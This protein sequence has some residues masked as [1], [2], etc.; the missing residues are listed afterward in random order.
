VANRILIILPRQLG[1]VLLGTPLAEVLRKRFPDAKIDWCAHPMAIT[2]LQEN[3]YLNQSFYYPIWSKQDVSHHSL[4]VK[5]KLWFL[6]VWRYFLFL[7]HLRQQKYHIVIDAMNNPRTALFAVISGAQTKVSFSVNALRNRA[8]TAL[9]PRKNLDDG[10][11]GHTR[12]KLLEPLGIVLTEQDYF[13]IYPV[14]PINVA[15]QNN[16]NA[17]LENI[18]TNHV[19]ASDGVLQEF[20]FIALS[21]THRRPVRRWPGQSYVALGFKIITELKQAVV[22]LWGPGEK[23]MIYALHQELQ[24]LLQKAD[25]SLNYSVFPPGFGLPELGFVSQK[26]QAW[27]GNSSGLSHVAV[28]GGAKTLEIHGPSRPE[29]W[30][31]P[32]NRKHHFLQRTEGCFGCSSNTCKLP[33]RECLDDLSVDRVFQQLKLLLNEK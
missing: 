21:A 20:K 25:I 33:R 28:A 14:I 2:L 16:V 18:V 4:W 13:N 22:W 1:D 6:F 31:H 29:N 30:C 24:Y 17:W 10:Y 11:L 23:D 32:N 3:P 19:S 12:I 27:V 9:I 26:A 15:Y 8:F 7:R 5:I